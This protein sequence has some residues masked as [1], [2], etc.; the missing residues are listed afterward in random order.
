MS[1]DTEIPR[2]IAYFSMER[3]LE[4]H[5]PTYSGGLGVLAGD[6]LRSAA[7]LGLP[8]V[9][10]T[11]LPRKGYFFQGLGDDARQREEPVAW[12]ID[13]V[14]SL[15]DATCRV[16]IEGRQVTV[17]AWRYV[18]TGSAGAEAPVLL[19]DTYVPENE[20]FDRTLTDSLYGGEARYRLCQES[21]LGVG[22]L[23]VSRT[24]SGHGSSWL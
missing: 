23:T 5:V 20:P 12:P 1:G 4:S 13:D 15:T 22:G 9:G 10:V 8:A 3:A 17:R 19:L 7:D 14:L 24:G 2:S 18:I 11:L 6:T 16:E 21:V